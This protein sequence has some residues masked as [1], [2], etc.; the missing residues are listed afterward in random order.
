MTCA[1][2]VILEQVNTYYIRY[3]PVYYMY[4]VYLHRMSRIKMI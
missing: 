1:R 2:R 3:M 4:K